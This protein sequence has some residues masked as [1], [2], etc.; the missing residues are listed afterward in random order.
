M[1]KGWN[2]ITIPLLS[3]KWLE[4]KVKM[5][6]RD[7]SVKPTMGKNSINGLSSWISF[8]LHPTSIQLFLPFHDYMRRLSFTRVQIRILLYESTKKGSHFPIQ[9]LHH[10]WRIFSLSSLKEVLSLLLSRKPRLEV[11]NETERENK[12]WGRHGKEG[13][14]MK[15]QMIMIMMMLSSSSFFTSSP[16][17]P[18]SL[19]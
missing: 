10:L 18:I 9:H 2:L 14:E 19:L 3:K 6:K 11:R 17:L 7:G 5:G 1:K 8:H 4:T 16:S 15:K 13:E 12:S